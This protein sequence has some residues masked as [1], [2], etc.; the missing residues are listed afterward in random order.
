VLAGAAAFA[1]GVHTR[2]QA[3]PSSS[4]PAALQ[5]AVKP[6]LVLPSQGPMPPLDGAV[7]W[8]NSP[9]LSAE[10]LRG[11]VVLVDFWTF[12]CINCRNALPHVVEWS[13]KYK[14]QGLVVIGVHTPEFAYEK[15]IDNV[16]NALGD[17]HVQFPVA[18]DNRFAIWRSFNNQYWPA[19]YFIDAEGQI[20][21]HHFGEGEYDKSEQVIQQLLDEKT[22]K[23]Q[24]LVQ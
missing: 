24:H 5:V 10:S 4:G 1:L 19:H 3:E 15:N 11:K 8:L 21:F 12:G 2:G 18:V 14:D 7:E 20:R 22:K 17:L 23:S 6:A 9:P 16:R 13:R